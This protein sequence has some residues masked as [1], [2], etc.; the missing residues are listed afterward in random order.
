MA[1]LDQTLF[2]GEGVVLPI[3][4][5]EKADGVQDAVITD[6][7]I[8]SLDTLCGSNSGTALTRYR[9]DVDPVARR[10]SRRGDESSPGLAA[11]WRWAANALP[12][13]GIALTP[14]S[15]GG[16]CLAIVVADTYRFVGRWVA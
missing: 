4:S 11:L 8:G 16:A 15:E 13:H 10:D 5:R 7:S 9:R 3:G 2:H 12:D 1:Q 14:A 6:E